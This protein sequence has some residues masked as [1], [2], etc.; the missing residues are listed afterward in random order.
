M[1][2]PSMI[3]V[4]F[5][6]RSGLLLTRVL[7]QDYVDKR[8]DL[9]A[10]APQQFSQSAVEKISCDRRSRQSLSKQ[11]T[12]PQGNTSAIEHGDNRDINI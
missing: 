4:V 7:M 5:I 9:H 8:N 12:N 2:V 3:Q 10:M 11:Y 1:A 6:N